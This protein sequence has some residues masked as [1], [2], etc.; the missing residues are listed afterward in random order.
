MNEHRNID[1]CAVAGEICVIHAG[2]R[3]QASVSD[4]SKSGCRLTMPEA[5]PPV[6]ARVELVLLEGL[7]VSGE[8]A[9]AEGNAGGVTFDHHITDALVRYF[10]LP[11][12]PRSASV[13]TKD[14]FGRPLPPLGQDGGRR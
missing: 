14:G 8:I 12:R 6:G 2:A 4:I 13:V 5:M 11:L 9:W 1:R 7:E 3:H 10:T